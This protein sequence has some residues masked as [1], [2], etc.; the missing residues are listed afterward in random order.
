MAGE[1][2]HQCRRGPRCAADYQARISGPLLDRIDLRIEVPAVSA[3]DLIQPKTGES[4]ETIAGR[5]ADARSVQQDRCSSLGIDTATNAQLS[6]SVI[7]RVAAPDAAGKQLL[8]EAA[9]RLKFSARGFHRVLKVARTLADLDLKLRPLEETLAD[10]MRCLADH[11]HLA[12][13]HLGTL[14]QPA[15]AT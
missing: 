4:S 15:R 7:E 13:R 2:G 12:P 6:N 1:P 11:G 9:N 10:Q 3:V 8:E 5:V 14:A